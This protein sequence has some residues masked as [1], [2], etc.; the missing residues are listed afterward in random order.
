MFVFYDP[1]FA[2]CTLRLGAEDRDFQN[3]FMLFVLQSDVSLTA[4]DGCICFFGWCT[5]IRGWNSRSLYWAI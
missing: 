1:I 4:T 3:L 5:F 2:N